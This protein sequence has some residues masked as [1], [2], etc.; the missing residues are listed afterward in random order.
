M[1]SLAAHYAVLWGR[2]ELLLSLPSLNHHF[3]G[4]EVLPYKLQ[5]GNVNFELSWGCAGIADYLQDMG[6]AMGAVGPR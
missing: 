6:T 3:I 1:T 4:P 2:R 5:P